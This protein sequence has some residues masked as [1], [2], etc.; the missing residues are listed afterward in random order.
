MRHLRVLIGT[1]VYQK[2]LKCVFK[3]SH[4]LLSIVQ[5]IV[6]ERSGGVPRVRQLLVTLNLRLTREATIAC[7]LHARMLLLLMVVLATIAPIMVVQ[8]RLLCDRTL[9]IWGILLLFML[10]A[11]QN[12]FLLLHESTVMPGELLTHLFVFLFRHHCEIS[13]NRLLKF[14]SG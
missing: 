3:P 13:L 5:V 10:L 8:V 9:C 4:L 7:L 11:E 1:Q 14:S 6:A 2:T 12:L